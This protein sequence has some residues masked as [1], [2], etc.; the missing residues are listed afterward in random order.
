VPGG[1]PQGVPQASPVRH[2]LRMDDVA[3][4]VERLG[5][6]SQGLVTARQ[7]RA[8]GVSRSRLQA[9]IGTR[10]V[11]R[12]ANRVYASASLAVVP[13]FVVTDEGVAPAYVARVRAVL[14]SLGPA[15][16]AADRTAAALRGWGMLVEPTRTIEVGVPHGRGTVR[17]RN[18]HA[19]QRRAAE[20][21]LVEVWAGTSAISMTSPAQTVIDCALA[22]PLLQA[23][24]ICDSAL[25]AG[26]VTVEE[27]LRVAR[28]LSGRRSAARARRVLGLCDPASGSVLESV[29]RVKMVLGGLSG[30][31]SQKLLRDT[32]G[33]HLR[34][35]FCFEA[36]GL[37]VEVDGRRWHP[38]P[39]RDQAR[40][41][42][43]VVLG[44]RVLRYTWRD[45]MDEG[46]RVVA[47][48]RAAVACV[49]PT[50]H[51]EAVRGDLAA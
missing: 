49:T 48:I 39:T 10:A 31:V 44:W 47:E 37:V 15:A 9:A 17:T 36:A 29:H 40:D 33:R 45:V 1:C 38:D 24:V 4:V 28:D 20:V 3:T 12:V 18:V 7:L 27:L 14:L 51:L 41:N 6:P 34:V 35:D 13:R 30:F 16:F 19:R 8:A 23:V 42:A 5:R 50:L 25:R 21:Q 46:D 22:L 2:G 43:L 32:P 11:V 26:D